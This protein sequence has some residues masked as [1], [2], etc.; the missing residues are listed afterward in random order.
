MSYR[1]TFKIFFLIT[2]SLA[3]VSTN[4]F[5]SNLTADEI[6][7]EA[8]KI[9]NQRTSKAKISMMITTSSGKRRT[10]V[11]DSYSKNFGEKN[12]MIYLKPSR[13]KNE[14]IL[15]LNNA[16]DIWM[17]FPRTNRIRKLATHAKK[18]KMEGSDFSYEDM[19][20]NNAFIT[21]FS[22]QSIGK[23]KVN[24]TI[25]YK[26]ELK[27]KKKSNSGYS[28][29]IVWVNKSNFCI[30]E[31][32][33]YNEKYPSVLEKILFCKDIK[34]IDGIPTPMRMIMKNAR[35]NTETIIEMFDIK[36]NIELDDTLF[37][38]RGMKG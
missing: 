4:L 12:L 27:R 23:E 20:A 26:L 7:K 21:D 34:I 29:L 5:S 2:I 28:R 37:T 3:F 24:K 9:M 22:S 16:D 15:M 31:I 36:Y 8:N 19:G 6:I 1:Q 32:E 38:E 18:R 17:Y 30:L 14:A 35:D 25:C 13:V 11:Y 10:F 33:Y